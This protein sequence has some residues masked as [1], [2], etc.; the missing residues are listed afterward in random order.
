MGVCGMST[1]LMRGFF[2]IDL[3]C[4][5]CTSAVR[6][7]VRVCAFQILSNI[8]RCPLPLWMIYFCVPGLL[9]SRSLSTGV[10][11]YVRESG[12]EV[13][14]DA[15]RRGVP[16]HLWRDQSS[17]QGRGE[18]AVIYSLH[19]L[20]CFSFLW[21]F[22]VLVGK[23]I[24]NL[25]FI[26]G[27]IY[28]QSI[29]PIFNLQVNR[30]SAMFMHFSVFFYLIIYYQKLLSFPLSRGFLVSFSCQ[31][32]GKCYAVSTSSP[33]KGCEWFKK[34]HLFKTLKK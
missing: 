28:L 12:A 6:V 14:A 27:N 25:L 4:W 34:M 13:G 2:C 1:D 32:Q 11:R 23:K 20:E 22:L 24:I 10:L 5:G 16:Y 21:V 29:T 31:M 15:W 19:L 8:H 17:S 3:F 18:P 30:Y 26:V 7:C 9:L 33:Y